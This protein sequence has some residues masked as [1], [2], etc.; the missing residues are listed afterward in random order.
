MHVGFAEG[1]SVPLLFFRKPAI[2]AT[3]RK[4]GGLIT[5]FIRDSSAFLQ[6]I[7]LQIRH[8]LFQR[9]NIVLRMRCPF[10]IAN[11]LPVRCHI[12]R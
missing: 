2:K 4:L 3:K 11:L 8:H 12:F 9:F 6:R 10:E 1:R 5:D 7:L